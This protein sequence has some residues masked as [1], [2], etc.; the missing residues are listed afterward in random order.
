MHAMRTAALLVALAAV[1]LPGLAARRVT[2]EQLEQMLA[3]TSAKSDADVARQ[4]E[5]VELSER[6]SGQRLTQLSAG[7][8]GEKARQAMLVLADLS[9]FLAPPAE[10]IPATATPDQAAQRRMMA[11][12]VGYLG[13]SLPLLPNLYANR[14]TE[15]FES[16]PEPSGASSAGDPEFHAAGR[17]SVI[18]LY[19]D[20]QEFVDAGALKTGKPKPPERGLTTWGEFGPVLGTVVIDAAR[21][22]LTW[23]HWELSATG[24]EAVFRYAVPREKSHYDVRFCCVAEAYG[25]ETSELRQRSG[26]HGEI[27]VD[28]DTGAILRLTAEADLDRQGPISLASIAVEYAPVEIGSRTYI[29]P[30]RAIALARAEDAKTLENAAAKTA[31]NAPLPPLE[32]ASLPVTKTGPEQTLLNDIAFRHYHLFRA[33]SRVLSDKEKEEAA[34]NPPAAPNGP[35]SGE[36]PSVENARPAQQVAEENMTASAEKASAAAVIPPPAIEAASAPAAEMAIPEISVA[37]AAGLPETPAIAHQTAAGDGFTLR[38]NSRL[39]DV[40]VVAI[41]K[42]GRPVTDLKPANFEIDDEGRKEDIRNFERTG[43]DAKTETAS[44]AVPAEP[45]GVI[46][47]RHLKDARAESNSI[48]LLIDSSNLSFGDFTDARQQVIKFLKALPSDEPV[49]LYAMKYHAFQVLEESTTDHE[50]LAVRLKK[51]MPS[52]QDIGNAGDEEE[53]HRQHVETVHSPEDLSNVNGNFTLDPA[54]QSEALDPKLADLGS[55]APGLALSILVDVGRHLGALPGHKSLVWVTSDNSL[56]D[57]NKM[58][59]TIEKGSKYIEPAALRVQETMNNA[60]VSVYPLDASRLEANVIDASIG[61]RNVELTPTF[62]KPAQLEAAQESADPQMRANADVNA[63]GEN[64]DLRPGRLTAQ[65]QQDLHPIM[66]V[67]RE[68]ADATGGRPIR[69]TGDI[70]GE[71]NSVADDGRATYLLAFSPSSAADGRYHRLTVK[72]VGRR[73]VTLRYRTGYEYNLEPTD[74]KER[75]TKAIWQPVDASDISLSATPSAADGTTLKLNIAATDLAVA[76]SGEWWTDKVG[77]FLVRRDDSGLHAQV[78]GQTLSLRLKPETYQRLLRDGIPFDQIVDPR[79]ETGSVR[80][81]VVDENSGRLGTI[82][83]PSATVIA[84][85]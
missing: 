47:N 26:Y 36:V 64:L 59:V 25:M 14:D 9:E 70:A 34:A 1:T 72:V 63:Y 11:L 18:V 7:L 41:D 21:S 2:V 37:I 65:M 84:A 77:I 52:A 27:T 75:F 10:E 12:T 19:R 24:P 4:L 40:N 53:H 13:K 48:V 28:P 22:E 5:E 66:G 50:E 46:S 43:G 68:I 81:V 76:Q 15:R 33:D 61:R 49:A 54:T 6:L 3:G 85:R 74:L 30:V 67:F 69:R 51:W 78:T 45:P 71:L 31:S 23:S 29:C 57:W 80:I 79:K 8:P 35:G 73:D 32:K 56:A 44:A 55:D 42:K 16:R 58:S 39:V 82:T 62:Q 20:G 38:I 17:S 83:L 60:H